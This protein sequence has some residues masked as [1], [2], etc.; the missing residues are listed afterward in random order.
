MGGVPPRC[1]R[2][3][4]EAEAGNRRDYDMKRVRRAAAVSGG[5]RQRI[6]DLKLLDDRTGP[7]MRDN[8]R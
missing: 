1:G 2:S 4:G 5:V 7:P 3:S 6:D 8:D